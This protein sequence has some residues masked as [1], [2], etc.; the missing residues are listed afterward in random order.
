[1]LLICIELN[2]FL[3]RDVVICRM[4]LYG[5]IYSEAPLGMRE[6]CILPSYA[7][8]GRMQGVDALH[9]DVDVFNDTPHVIQ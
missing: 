1:M 6:A 8:C 9:S 4:G 3:V 5:D 2:H 7:A